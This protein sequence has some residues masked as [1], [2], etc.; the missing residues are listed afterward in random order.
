MYY[1][2]EQGS[3]IDMRICISLFSTVYFR[4]IISIR[5]ETISGSSQLLG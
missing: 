2:N 5:L 3:G 1:R 4:L